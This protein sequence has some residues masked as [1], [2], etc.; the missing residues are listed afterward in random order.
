MKEDVLHTC[1][2]KRGQVV[3]LGDINARV[4][5]GKVMMY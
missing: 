4:H 1:M 5:G 2:M 3:L